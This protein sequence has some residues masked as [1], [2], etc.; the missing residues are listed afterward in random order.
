MM[1][2]MIQIN[3]DLSKGINSLDFGFADI[4]KINEGKED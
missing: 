2:S 4:K 3:V 1:N